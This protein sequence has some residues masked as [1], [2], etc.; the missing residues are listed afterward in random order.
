MRM[1]ECTGSCF[2]GEPN[3]THHVQCVFVHNVV[4]VD[5]GERGMNG[6]VHSA[7]C[8]QICSG[9]VGRSR[10]S[11]TV[12]AMERA[13]SDEGASTHASGDQELRCDNPKFL[14]HGVDAAV[15]RDVHHP[16]VITVV[17]CPRSRITRGDS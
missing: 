11:S 1:T 10:D 17:V 2:G 5:T 12:T 8:L 4:D 14:V 7:H 6:D 3:P 13:A 15:G 16:D 9:H